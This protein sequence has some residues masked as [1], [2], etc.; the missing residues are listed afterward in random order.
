MAIVAFIGLGNM[1]IGMAGRVLDAGHALHLYNRTASRGQSLVRRGA[2]QYA[3][4]REACAGADAV[5]S[6]VADDP[7]SR[8][9]WTGSS[10]ILSASTVPGAFAV[11]CSTLSHDWVME[12]AEEARHQ[13]LRYIDAPVTGLP[14]AAAAGELTLL[15][16]AD[17]HDLE[18]ARSFLGAI[19]QR[20]LHFGAIGTGTAYKLMV[21]L[22]GAIQIA[23]AAEGM[24]I[25]ERAGLDLGLVAEAVAT[26]QAGSPQVTRNCRRMADGNH[27]RDIVFTPQLRLKD[28]DYALQLA[29]KLGV[30]SPFGALAGTAFQQLCALGFQHKNESAILEVARR[31]TPS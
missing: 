4:P 25:A 5:I 9:V 23:S 1:G 12:L 28:V 17:T 7:A 10:G 26:G 11:E 29:R 3:T 22:L 19:S 24:A 8:A 2:S 6:M 16:G 15:V 21:N 14:Q 27:D 18:A 13:G 31:Q 30:G 20:L